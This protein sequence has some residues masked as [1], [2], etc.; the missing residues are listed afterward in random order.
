[1]K[2][3]IKLFIQLFLIFS[4]VSCQESEILGLGDGQI[5]DFTENFGSE[6]A[7]DFIGVV[8][9]KT[10]VPIAGVDVLIG[11]QS[12][13]TDENGV[14]IIR[15]ASVREYFAY[16]KAEKSGYS[17][18]STTL[19]PTDGVNKVKMIMMNTTTM[20]VIDSGVEVTVSLGDGTSIKF[21]GNFIDK[22]S[23]AHN[24][25]VRV[26][27]TSFEPED[28]DFYF[29]IPGMPYGANRLGNER[30]LESFGSVNVELSASD[31]SLLYLPEDS[32]A[33]ISIPMN[34]QLQSV[35]Q[36]II[37]LWYFDKENGYWIEDGEA[38]LQGNK[39]VGLINHPSC[40]NVSK[41]S[42]LV[43]LNISLQ[44]NATN[45]I[46]N[47]KIAISNTSSNYPYNSRFYHTNSDGRY[48]C[49]APANRGI[50][51][52]AYNRAVCGNTVVD[53][54]SLYTTSADQNVNLSIANSSDTISTTISGKQSDC[55]ENPIVDGYV[56]LS[57]DSEQ[58]FDLS[59]DG[60]FEI[61]MLHCDQETIFK[62]QSIDYE[63]GQASEE[64][65]YFF[66]EPVTYLGD[67]LTCDSIGE[68]V[69]FSIDDGNEKVFITSVIYSNFISYNIGYNAP[70]M[71]V[72]ENNSSSRFKLFG[73]LNDTT[74]EGV[75]GNWILGDLVNRGLNIEQVLDVSNTNNNISYNVVKIGV[76][77]DYIDMHFNGDYEDNSGNPHTI[78]GVIHVRRDL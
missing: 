40:W 27:L 58:F 69:Q 38:N 28:A 46:A 77:G 33:E 72:F 76:A 43:N 16:I 57:V 39:Y 75:Y 45:A 61:T 48:N 5:G 52:K 35:A 22:D 32:P 68:F 60:T 8:L 20:E 15:A 9:D 4:I 62:A 49:I 21:D 24:G 36:T 23:V 31:G 55:S 13:V 14:F 2:L 54:T 63:N 17:D 6:V 64:I 66:T 47:Q 56:L 26:R 73:L 29:K 18:A 37:P 10:A 65:N 67:I 51:I 53:N 42:D 1:M 3:T 78:I 50:D 34:A 41:S 70:S 59:T 74:Q 11:D 25:I 44:D 30:L 7:R 19:I 71:A 12:A